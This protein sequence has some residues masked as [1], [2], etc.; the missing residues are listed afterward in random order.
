MERKTYEFKMGTFESG[1]PE[2]WLQILINYNKAL[3][4]TVTYMAVGNITF[5]WMTIGGEAL[6]EYGILRDN[7]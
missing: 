5:L 4:G 6:R 3:T 7:H 2:D 1:Y